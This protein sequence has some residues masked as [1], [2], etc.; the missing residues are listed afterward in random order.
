MGKLLT[1]EMEGIA[2]ME[3]ENE[4]KDQE[5]QQPQLTSKELSCTVVN[6]EVMKVRRERAAIV[7][8]SRV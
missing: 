1:Q 7:G 5:E 6:K 3:D 8:Q 4:G 2:E